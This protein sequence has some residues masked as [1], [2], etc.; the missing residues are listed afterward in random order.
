[1]GGLG[2]VFIYRMQAALLQLSMAL[3]ARNKQRKRVREVLP[4][5]SLS[6]GDMRTCVRLSH[7]Y[8]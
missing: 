5:L 2:E 7:A 1:M 8:V 3:L 4:L 6:I